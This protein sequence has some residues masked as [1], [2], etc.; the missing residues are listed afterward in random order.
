MILV[1]GVMVG[2]HRYGGGQAWGGSVAIFLKEIIRRG[3]GERVRVNVGV[4]YG[5]W[6]GFCGRGWGGLYGWF[7]ARSLGEFFYPGGI[8]V[9]F[10]LVIHCSD[11]G[12]CQE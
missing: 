5:V 1:L 10:I 6:N 12:W 4:R 8:G 9:K 7:G 2:G 11:P 3:V